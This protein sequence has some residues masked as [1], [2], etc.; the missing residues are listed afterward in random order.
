MTVT[1][2]LSPLLVSLGLLLTRYDRFRRYDGDDG[3]LLLLY[4]QVPC[5]QCHTPPAHNE[6]VGWTCRTFRFGWT[7]KAF[8][9]FFFRQCRLAGSVKEAV[10][11]SNSPDMAR[12]SHCRSAGRYCGPARAVPPEPAAAQPALLPTAAQARVTVPSDPPLATPTPGARVWRPP[13]PGL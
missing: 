6:A 7:N 12:V 5:H 11:D 1:G 8:F 10:P 2:K 9:D 4:R 13:R 3:A